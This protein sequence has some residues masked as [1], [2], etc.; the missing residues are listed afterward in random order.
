MMNDGDKEGKD[1][2]MRREGV[3]TVKK[4][5]KF[6]ISLCTL[7]SLDTPFLFFTT[8]LIYKASRT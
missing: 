7:V 8:K 6:E 2:K 5:R 3:P 4:L 1:K